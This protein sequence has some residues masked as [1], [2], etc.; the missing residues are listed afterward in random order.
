[1]SIANTTAETIINA[2]II[3]ENDQ[4]SARVEHLTELEKSSE[5]RIQT[6]TNVQTLRAQK[7]RFQ[8]FRHLNRLLKSSGN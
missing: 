1:M 5:T 6:N 7:I 3:E 2:G 8:I 4:V